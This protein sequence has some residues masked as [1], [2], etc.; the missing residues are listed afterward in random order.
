[1]TKEVYI[2]K[3]YVIV[4]THWDYCDA[5][6]YCVEYARIHDSFD[7]AMDEIKYH[8]EWELYC[9]NELDSNHPK[10]K[11]AVEDSDGNI[12]GYDYPF[13]ADYNG[14][15]H[16]IIRFWDGDDYWNVSTYNIHELVEEENILNKYNEILKL[17]HGQKIAVQV[18]S[19]VEDDGSKWYYYTSTKYGDSDAYKTI[20][21]AYKEADSYLHG[22]GELW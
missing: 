19:Y 13:R 11:V 16:C 6:P 14:V 3:K 5:I 15:N 9:L 21:E 22:V 10:E 12:V 7:D 8:V 17:A 4:H 20:E 2:H 18:K 1:M